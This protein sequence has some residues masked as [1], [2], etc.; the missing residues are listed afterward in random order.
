MKHC[1]WLL[2]SQRKNMLAF[3][4]LVLDTIMRS[5]ELCIVELYM[6]EIG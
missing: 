5:G 1:A 6:I 3:T 4:F 2:M